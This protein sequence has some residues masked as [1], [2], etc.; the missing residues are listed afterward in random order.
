MENKY[1]FPSKD[2]F[3]YGFEFEMVEMCSINKGH[4]QLQFNK[5]VLNSF[6]SVTDFNIYSG[7]RDKEIRVKYLDQQDIEELGWK[8]VKLKRL[9]FNCLFEFIVDEYKYTLIVLTDNETTIS[10]TMEDTTIT[11]GVNCKPLFTGVVKNKSELKK[12]MKQL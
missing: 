2:E 11:D 7:L 9:V 10:I 6:S 5:K 8:Q 1:Y 3:H 4:R 12:L